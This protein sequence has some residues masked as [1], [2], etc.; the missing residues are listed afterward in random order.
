LIKD[1]G[2]Y[3]VENITITTALRDEMV[4]VIKDRII[5]NLEA[6]EQFLKV[7]G[8]EDFCA[9][10]YTY[11]LEEYG[12]ILFLKDS[13]HNLPT[14]NTKIKFRYR[15]KK[16]K[17]DK[18]YYGFLAHDDKFSRM[19]DD[20]KL[21]NR[22]KV[23]TRGDFEPNDVV[24]RDYEV[25]L[26]ADFEARMA[27]FFADFKDENTILVSPAVDRDVLEENVPK[28][29]HFMRN[30]GSQLSSSSNPP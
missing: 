15:S 10:L 14:D 1:K 21:E 28:F 29:L 11:A 22:C 9:G 24:L 8:Y 30:S 2:G 23:L 18:K 7:K 26:I 16:D 27:L 20:T 3:P 12:K 17:N 4:S 6:I 25:G 13:K 5:R 19:I